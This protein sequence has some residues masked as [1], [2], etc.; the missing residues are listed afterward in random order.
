MRFTASCRSFGSC[1][2]TNGRPLKT[3]QDRW[4]RTNTGARLAHGGGCRAAFEDRHGSSTSLGITFVK[5]QVPRVVPTKRP[6]A[7]NS[8]AGK[9]SVSP[10]LDLQA[11]CPRSYPR[12]LSQTPTSASSVESQHY[13]TTPQARPRASQEQEQPPPS[14]PSR[15]L[16]RR[17]PSQLTIS[18]QLQRRA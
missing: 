16:D 14:K 13:P 12:P 18:Q 7:S 5:T 1:V 17:M 10:G 2:R 11:A 6:P 3:A 9:S 8:L 15:P 4:R